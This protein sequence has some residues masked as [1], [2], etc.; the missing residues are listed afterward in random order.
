M[1][2]AEYRRRRQAQQPRA[3]KE[4]RPTLTQQEERFLYSLH[5]KTIEYRTLMN[6]LKEHLPRNELDDIL[7]EFNLR[8]KKARTNFEKQH[9]NYEWESENN[10]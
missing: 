8:L 2:F 3:M 7:V 6:T 5:L 4:R 10:G 1:N 9:Y